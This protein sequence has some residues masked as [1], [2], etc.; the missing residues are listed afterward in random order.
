MQVKG[1]VSSG[2]AG[3]LNVDLAAPIPEPATL[4]LL[5]LGGIFAA[6]SRKS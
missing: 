5:T 6:R 4:A 2:V 1:S 3:S